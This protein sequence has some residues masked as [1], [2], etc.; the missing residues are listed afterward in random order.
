MVSQCVLDDVNWIKL[1]WS[2]E[3]DQIWRD[4]LATVDTAEKNSRT[5]KNEMSTQ[6]AA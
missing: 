4:E 1:T 5:I 2:L 3:N 6:V